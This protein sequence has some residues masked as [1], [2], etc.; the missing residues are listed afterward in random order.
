MK[1]TSFIKF[2]II[3]SMAL[4]FVAGIAYVFPFS[5]GASAPSGLPATVIDSFTKQVGPQ[6]N[7]LISTSTP[8]CSS[9]VVSTVAKPVMLVFTR[10]ASTTVS[11]TYGHLQGA[12]TTVAYDSGLYGCNQITA[13]GFDATTTITITNLN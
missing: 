10:S 11:A 1:E 12:S 5:V 7:T 3:A 6:G 9:R 4:C 8:S 13:Y 2:I